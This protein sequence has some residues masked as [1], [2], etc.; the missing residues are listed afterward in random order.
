MSKARLIYLVLVASLFA[1]MLAAHWKP[2]GMSNGG[3]FV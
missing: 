1:Y 3:G 2:G